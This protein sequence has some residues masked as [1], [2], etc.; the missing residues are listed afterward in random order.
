M[1]V[2]YKSPFC[3]IE[4]VADSVFRAVPCDARITIE[5]EKGDSNYN[6]IYNGVVVD[7]SVT[8]L[9]CNSDSELIVRQGDERHAYAV[10]PIV[11]PVSINYKRTYNQFAYEYADRYNNE[12]ESIQLGQLKLYAVEQ[13]TEGR[14]L[15]SLFNQME[16]AYRKIKAI[17]EKPKSHLKSINEV[18]PIETVKRIGHESIPYLAAHSEDWL[19][20]T[21]S[22]LKPSRLFSRVEDDNYQIYE[23]RVVKTL[24][25]LSINFLRKKAKEYN[26][27]CK[28]LSGIMNSSVQTKSFGFDVTF[29]KA[30]AELI[31]FDA[32]SNELRSKTFKLMNG[33]YDTAQLLLKKYRS[34]RKTRL[35]RYLKKTKPVTNPLNETN[36]LLM[37]KHYNV[38]FN[39]WHPLHKEIVLQNHSDDSEVKDQN[40]FA[41]YR[42]FCKVLCG[43]AAHVLNFDIIDDGHYY[44]QSDQLRLTIFDV[45]GIISV[46]IKDGTKRFIELT[47]GMAVP[48]EDGESRGKFTLSD[49]CLSWES[50]VSEDEIEEFCSMFKTRSS[51]GK[52]QAEEK[53]KYLALKSAIGQQQRKCGTP[54][55]N[56]FVVLPT[57]IELESDTRSAFKQLMGKTAYE[58]AEK[59]EADFAIVALPL[60]KDD[61]QKVTSYA[62]ESGANI[63]MLPLSMFDINSFR[64][65]QNVMLRQIVALD[66]GSCPSCGEI[67]RGNDNIKVCDNCGQMML[68]KTICPNTQC[69]HAYHYINYEIAPEIASK[70]QKIETAQEQDAD[71]FY[72]MDSL[73]QY[74]DIVKMYVDDGK[75]RTIC[76]KC[77]K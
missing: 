40:I 10:R 69:R 49:G 30:V 13:S 60:C 29:Q 2:F 33:L 6:L 67:M 16:E 47:S 42:L 55:S 21:V 15:T 37:D 45:N 4:L 51:R 34:L 77:G 62:K 63:M 73:Y 43:Y 24:I 19:A 36:I 74:K 26:D 68:V 66:S 65:L 72:K 39:L 25:D 7:S 58:I 70:M 61:E 76:P 54:K 9:E 75:V 48:I 22:G 46:T 11:Q 71:D 56:K 18:R 1:K 5:L 8:S 28:Q 31:S 32:Q 27:N 35:Y 50:D 23:N 17:C 14:D 3:S 41:D 44:R 38:A 20:R 57:A 64:R 59:F 12:I 52:D 53:R